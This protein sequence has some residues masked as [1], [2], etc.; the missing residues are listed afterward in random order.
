MADATIEAFKKA[1]IPEKIH[2]P[3]YFVGI[4][5]NYRNSFDLNQTSV[6]KSKESF[7]YLKGSLS[8]LEEEYR[9]FPFKKK[10]TQTFMNML[11]QLIDD[12]S[13]D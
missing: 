1:S 13:E 10:F 4:W 5:G 2:F 6:D 3:A 8:K 11:D 7:E 12:E 9:D